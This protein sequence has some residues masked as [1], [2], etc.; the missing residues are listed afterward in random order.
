MRQT[1]EPLVST[2]KSFLGEPILWIQ[3]ERPA[4]FVMSSKTTGAWPGLTNPPAVMG[5]RCSSYWAGAP[6][7]P[8]M[9]DC[10]ALGGC[11]GGCCGEDAACEK[12][13][14]GHET[15]K[16]LPPSSNRGR[17]E[18]GIITRSQCIAGCGED[19]DAGANAKSRSIRQQHRAASKGLRQAPW[20]LYIEKPIS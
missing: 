4:F 15:S 14:A 2:M 11:G 7:P 12:Q 9:P 20:E 17:E 10:C 16:R 3:P 13:T 19:F 18:D 5:R 1:P 8:A 6:R